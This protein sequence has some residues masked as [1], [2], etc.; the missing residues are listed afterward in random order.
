MNLDDLDPLLWAKKP[1]SQC[2]LALLIT[3]AKE[4]DKR[5]AEIHARHISD[6]VCDESGRLLN[7]WDGLRWVTTAKTQERSAA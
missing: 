5:L 2:A 3:G 7:R 6:G 1:K 4:G